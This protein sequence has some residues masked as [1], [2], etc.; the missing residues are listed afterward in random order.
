MERQDKQEATRC[1]AVCGATASSGD[2]RQEIEA[3]VRELVAAMVQ[4]NSIVMEDLAG[5]MITTSGVPS[6]E[7]ARAV[8]HIGVQSEYVPVM[9]FGDS[10]RYSSLPRTIR[11]MM[12]WNT[13]RTP[14][15]IKHIYLRGTESQRMAGVA[16]I[17]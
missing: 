6:N 17:A 1:R 13:S 7:A 16:E 11:L 5:V 4:T 9:D 14:R 12:L 3:V 10:S 15:E 2:S 8:R